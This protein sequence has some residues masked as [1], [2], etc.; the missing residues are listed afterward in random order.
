MDVRE[1]V[2]DRLF[3]SVQRELFTEYEAVFSFMETVECDKNLLKNMVA[4]VSLWTHR[5]R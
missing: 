1:S 5:I 2:I 3:S 4:V